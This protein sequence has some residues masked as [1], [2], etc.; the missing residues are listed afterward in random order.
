VTAVARILSISS[1]FLV[2]DKR[3]RLS[4]TLVGFL[5]AL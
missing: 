4:S 5:S 3:G 1:A 2:P